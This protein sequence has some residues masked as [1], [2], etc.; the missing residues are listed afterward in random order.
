MCLFDRTTHNFRIG[1]NCYKCDRDIEFTQ[2]FPCRAH[3]Y[4]KV[5]YGATPREVGCHTCRRQMTLYFFC[6]PTRWDYDNVI[7]HRLKELGIQVR[8]IDHEK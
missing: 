4:D 7:R 8:N 2:E 5:V 1:M 3:E 6:E